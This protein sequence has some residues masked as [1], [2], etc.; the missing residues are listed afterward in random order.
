MEYKE[1]KII[2]N[3]KK[4]TLFDIEDALTKHDRFEDVEKEFEEV[5][6][7]TKCSTGCGGCHDKIIGII[8]D[9]LHN[10]IN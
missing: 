5:Q 4:V 1:N 8:S 7:L 3:C 2:C 6:R 9:M 10:G